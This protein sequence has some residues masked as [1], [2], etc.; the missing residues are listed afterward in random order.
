VTW[1]SSSGAGRTLDASRE[2]PRA[3]PAP[4][5]IWH[6]CGTLARMGQ[7]VQTL[8]V[9]AVVTSM[10]LVPACGFD[11]LPTDDAGTGKT[12]ELE[13]ALS[14]HD[15]ELPADASDISYTVHMS[16]DSHAVGL[17]LRT[18]S[19]GLDELLTSLG[20]R[21]LD[22]QREMNPWNVSSRLSSH[23]PEQFGWNL[24]GIA[25]Y[26]GLEIHSG[27]SLGSTGVLVDLDEPDAPV[28]YVEA[29]NCC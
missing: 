6:A 16:I 20:S 25:S 15:L 26:A 13:E 29:L 10:A 23:S 12:E 18:T 22:L 14:L 24:A 17:R 4:R 2:Y 11:A 5:G 9:A 21:Q 8:A 27:S 3:R 7:V 19:S 1:S 28:V